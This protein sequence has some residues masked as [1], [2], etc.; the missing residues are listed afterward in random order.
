MP[1]LILTRRLNEAVSVDGPAEITVV[2]LRPESVRLA[3]RAP[4][5]TTILRDDVRCRRVLTLWG[6]FPIGDER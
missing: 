6:A 5:T 4:E 2:R 1:N 3:F